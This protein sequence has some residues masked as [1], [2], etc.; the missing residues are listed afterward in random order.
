MEH[1]PDAL[2]VAQDDGT[3]VYVNDRFSALTGMAPDAILGGDAATLF[4][5]DDPVSSSATWPEDIGSLFGSAAPGRRL[6]LI[7]ADRDFL[8]VDA[9]GEGFRSQQVGH[10][11]IG[12]IREASQSASTG[13]ERLSIGSAVFDVLEAL[14]E[15]ILVCDALGIVLMANSSARMLQGLP[16]DEDMVGAPFPRSTKLRRPEG[17]TPAT[18]D[19]PLE[20]ALQG[21]ATQGEQFLLARAEGDDRHILASARPLMVENGEQGALLVLRDITAQRQSEAWLTHL[22]MHDPLTG[23]ANRHLLVDHLRR[24]VAQTG[25]RG[26][27]VS[28]VYLDLDGFKSINDS[29]GHGVGDEVLATVAQRVRGAVRPTDVVA[30]LGGDEF[31]VAHSSQPDSGSVEALVGRVTKCMTAPF[32][33]RQHLLTVGASV[34]YVS[35]TS[36]DDPLA[37][38]VRAD[39]EMFRHKKAARAAAAQ[40]RPVR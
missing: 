26:H 30:R 34:G 24:M 1:L 13:Q 10:C 8:A 20:R 31:V 38:L 36:D 7:S 40:G 16:A 12:L 15:G 18:P 6:S 39:R 19:H 17:A 25:T 23:L 5:G 3:I 29:Y 32:R 33:V 21:R 28:V 37:L 11:H 27:A 35:T 9:W 2:V 4:S 14:D 22:A